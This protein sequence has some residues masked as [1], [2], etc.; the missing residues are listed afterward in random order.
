MLLSQ[1]WVQKLGWTLLHFLW[2][3]TAIAVAYAVFRRVLA[4]SLS[5][6]GRYVL[7]CSALAAMAAAPPL[8]FV[9]IP[10]MPGSSAWTISAAESQRL[11]PAVV[12][13]WM[14]GVLAFSIRLVGGWRFASHLRSSSHP[15]PLEWQRHLERVAAR[16]G[17][18]AA[19]APVGLV[20]GECPHGNR[21]AA[22]GDPGACR[23]S[24]GIVS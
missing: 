18:K 14:L 13:L 20:A 21:M 22:S 11:L 5:A 16:V 15:A 17:G 9:L 2:Q 7:S 6:Q 23:V 4:R 3:G 12:A 1:I 19:G 10:N 24:H 8:T